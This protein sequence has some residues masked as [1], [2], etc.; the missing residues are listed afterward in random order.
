MKK[1]PNYNLILGCIIAGLTV[2]MIIVGIFWT[3]YEPTAMSGGEKLDAP[4]LRHLLGTDNFGR[5]IFSRVLE[6]ARSTMLIAAAVVAIGASVGTVVGAFTGYFGGRVD[7]VLMRFNDMLAAFPSILL[8]LVLISLLGSGKTNVIIAL[9]ILFIPSYARIVRAE[10]ARQAE[11]DYVKS[12]RLMGAGHLRIMFVHILPNA[13]PVL[14]SSI[15]IG[16]NN[17]VLAEASMSYL[18]IGV[19]PPDASLGRMLSDSQTYL[20]SAPWYAIGT[21]AAIVLLILGFGLISEGLGDS[22]RA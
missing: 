10:F 16:F 3:P 18:S 1:R 22:R 2:G 14:L 6:G 11:L 8:A 20:L 21:G 19:Q 5:D 12:A 7:A 13:A 15:A 9:G 17:A 4:S